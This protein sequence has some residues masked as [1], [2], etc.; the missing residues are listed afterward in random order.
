MAELTL[1]PTTV[2]LP[3]PLLSQYGLGSCFGSDI[4][5]ALLCLCLFSYLG[6]LPETLLTQ[7]VER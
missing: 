1:F 5:R 2:T 7:T 3:V 4:I 6:V